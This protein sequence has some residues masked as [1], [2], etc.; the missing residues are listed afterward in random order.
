MAELEQGGHD[1]STLMQAL[2]SGS[3]NPGYDATAESAAANDTNGTTGDMEDS[4]GDG[5]AGEPLTTVAISPT[6]YGKNGTPFQVRLVSGVQGDTLRIVKKQMYI[7]ARPVIFNG[8]T[9]EVTGSLGGSAPTPGKWSDIGL[10]IT[11]AY[12]EIEID[13]TEGTWCAPSKYSYQKPKVKAVWKTSHTE[14]KIEEGYIRYSVAIATDMPAV[15]GGKVTSNAYK[16]VTGSPVNVID[17]FLLDKNMVEVDVV[18]DIRFED[19]GSEIK[20]HITRA[21]CACFKL[22][23]EDA[24]PQE[25]CKT[26]NSKFT[27]VSDAEIPRVMKM[28]TM[29]VVTNT[30]YQG[31]TLKQQVF[32]NVRVVQKQGG[33]NPAGMSPATPTTEAV[34]TAT[35]HSAEHL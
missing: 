18:T 17:P 6:Q 10:A 15:I 19:T 26:K 12:I 29:R 5:G 20:C 33:S 14:T 13:A 35:P 2:A 25:D 34:F 23:G 4:F 8:E 3:S 32:S 1:H 30:A 27:K 16:H 11:S 31:H 22:Y 21:R 24:T 28:Q 7:P 9:V